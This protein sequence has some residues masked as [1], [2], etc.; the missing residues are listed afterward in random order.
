MYNCGHEIVDTIGRLNFEGNVIPNSWY[1]TLKKENG[2]PDLN[3]M[4]LLSD[5]VY[6]Y[7][8]TIERDEQTG[9][10]KEVKKKFKSDLLQRSYKQ[11]EEQFGLTMKQAKETLVRLENKN[12]IKRVFRTVD[13]TQGRL[14]NI[15]FIELNIRGLVEI[16][17]PESTDVCTKKYGYPSRKVQMPVPE[18]TDITEITTDFEEEEKA[19]A[20]SPINFYEQN[21]FGTIGSHISEK[22]FMWC[23]DL[24]SELVL[25][26]M[27]LA[28]ERG[29][30]SW[31]YVEKI[32]I[33]WSEK[34]IKTVQQ[35]QALI[36][37]HLEKRGKARDK[38]SGKSQSGRDI[39]D[40]NFDLN[41][42]EEE[43]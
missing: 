43:D 37:E 6:W 34:K 16:T 26:A 13:T 9:L 12:V 33:S 20:E 38:P 18:S 39:P 22:I 7:R 35:A 27:K 36:N 31:S 1:Q 11:I 15:M 14:P 5:F 24:S 17:F 29:A 4:I 25:E 23:D 10:V 42:G 8:P 40:F 3:A 2:K 41:A 32:L 19:P 21:G 30:K 28:V